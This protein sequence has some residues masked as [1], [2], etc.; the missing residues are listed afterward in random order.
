MNYTKSDIEK[1]LNKIITNEK[2]TIVPVGNHD[3]GR[4]LVYKIDTG[5]TQY[6]FNLR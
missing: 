5:N 6:I 3:I 4:H 1:I 2:F